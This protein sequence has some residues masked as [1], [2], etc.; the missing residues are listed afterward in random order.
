MFIIYYSRLRDATFGAA[1]RMTAEVLE[2]STRARR[3]LISMELD[4]KGS[5]VV[6][7]FYQFHIND[8]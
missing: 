8:S 5:R 3:E 4:V 7:N 2:K 6:L 1:G